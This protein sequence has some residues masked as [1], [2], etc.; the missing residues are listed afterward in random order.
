MKKYKKGQPGALLVR[1]NLV[2]GVTFQGPWQ[3]RRKVFGFKE[4]FQCLLSHPVP[5]ATI[6]GCSKEQAHGLQHQLGVL[7]T[8]QKWGSSLRPEN[9]LDGL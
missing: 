3:A 5:A 2:V 9:L 1:G 4:Y 6:Y 8:C 7:Q